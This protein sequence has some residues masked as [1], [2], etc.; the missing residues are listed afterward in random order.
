MHEACDDICRS[1]WTRV[2]VEKPFGKDLESN[3]QLDRDLK[4][5]LSEEQIFR[6]DHYLGKELIENLTVLR[7]ANLVFEPLWS[8]SFIRNVQVRPMCSLC[9]HAATISVDVDLA[10]ERRCGGAAFALGACGPRDAMPEVRDSGWPTPRGAPRPPPVIKGEKRAAAPR[11]HACQR[12]QTMSVHTQT[13]PR[14]QQPTNRPAYTHPL[15]NS[16]TMHGSATTATRTLTYTCASGL[17]IA[18]ITAIPI[19]TGS[20]KVRMLCTI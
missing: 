2:I 3:R 14:K 15:C 17:A 20:M 16:N 10:N 8:R 12:P 9:E 4:Q 19:T 6:I 7:F 18:F 5:Y 13:E 11:D 1:G